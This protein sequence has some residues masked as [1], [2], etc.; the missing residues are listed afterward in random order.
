M[1]TFKVVYFLY[2]FVLLKKIW[3]E[4]FMTVFLQ[5]SDIEQKQ[6]VC[7]FTKRRPHTRRYR[8]RSLSLMGSM[9][10]RT[11]VLCCISTALRT[12]LR[13]Q[14]LKSK[15]MVNQIIVSA[16]HECNVFTH[17]CCPANRTA[18][19][20]QVFAGRLGCLLVY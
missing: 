13:R 18:T 3:S 11:Y 7:V 2:C 12:K 14:K 9:P 5:H 16:I 20:F 17:G 6:C 1:F 4:L 8:M 19:K 15:D 10:D